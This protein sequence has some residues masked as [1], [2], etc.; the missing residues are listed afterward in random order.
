MDAKIRSSSFL[1]ILEKMGNIILQGPQ[2]FPAMSKTTKVSPASEIKFSQ[3]SLDSSNTT[4]PMSGPP[5]PGPSAL[6]TVDV[7][8]EAN[9]KV[10]GRAL[11]ESRADM[12]LT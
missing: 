5:F 8:C 1:L 4:F 7:C 3:S 12:D 9:L 6:T 11:A 10:Q 2:D